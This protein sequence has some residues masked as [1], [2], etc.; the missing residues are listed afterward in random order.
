MK[1]TFAYAAFVRRFLFAFSF[2]FFCGATLLVPFARAVSGA[3]SS[4]LSVE[5]VAD[6]GPRPAISLRTL[7]RGAVRVGDRIFFFASDEVSRSELW[8][9]DGTQT[10]TR[11]V[12]DVSALGVDSSIV[13]GSGLVA[14]QGR[15]YF[16]TLD[17][18]AGLRIW[19]SDGSR[20]GTVPFFSLDL[21]DDLE[22]AQPPEVVTAALGRDL[23]FLRTGEEGLWD[24]WRTDGSPSGTRR[25]VS[26]PAPSASSS[27]GS[28]FFEA[29]GRAYF[30]LQ[31]QFSTVTDLWTTAGTAAGTV[32]L[33]SVP[34]LPS[35][36]RQPVAVGGRLFFIGFEADHGFELWTSDGSPAGTRIVRDLTPGRRRTFFEQFFPGRRA[37]Y[38]TLSTPS[39][40]ELWRSDGSEAGTSRLSTVDGTFA[41]PAAEV[42]GSLLFFQAGTL[43]RARGT[44]SPQRLAPRLDPCGPSVL[45]AGRFE[46]FADDGARGCRL[47][48]SDGT[49]GG[50]V[51]AVA[52][53]TDASEGTL[54]ALEDRLVLFSPN[55]SEIQV[56]AGDRVIPLRRPRAELRSGA[57]TFLVPWQGGIAFAANGTSRRAIYRSNGTATGTL[58]IASG[59]LWSPLFLGL[60]S[61]LIPLGENL[62]YLSLDGVGSSGSS[63]S[64]TNP[65]Q[66]D[67]YPVGAAHD[68]RVLF[69]FAGRAYWLTL[70][71]DGRDVELRSTDGTEAGTATVSRLFD[72]PVSPFGGVTYVPDFFVVRAE[73]YLAFFFPVNPN[74]VWTTDGTAAGTRKAVRLD[75][76]HDGFLHAGVAFGDGMLFSTWATQSQPRIWLTDDSA[77]GAHPIDNLAIHSL[78]QRLTA[79]GRL[80]FFTARDG[81]GVELWATDGTPSGAH[82]VR[83]IASGRR[84]S[85]PRDLTAVGDRLFFTADDGASGRELWSSDG[86][87]AGTVRVADLVPG[88]GGS[89]PQKLA[90][91]LTEGPA[92][93]LAFAANDGVH[94]LEPWL[95]EADGTSV[96]MLADVAPGFT[97]SSPAEFLSVGAHLYFAATTR[98]TGR[99]LWKATLQDPENTTP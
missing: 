13:S 36:P 2:L 14:A 97:S 47:W 96:R 20:E 31:D 73:R 93:V 90:A 32:R 57:P 92:P 62:A 41:T 83:D 88:P 66:L 19:R 30:A 4:S 5:P 12:L 48:R 46:F 18:L 84:G 91:V 78:D 69:S 75:G 98:A 24:L 68:G 45:A 16:Q 85:Y 79:V 86:T 40:R 49:A 15:A 11:R 17:P 34:S 33:A 3:A 42:E 25:L 37:L 6:L 94:G 54:V 43:W 38:F 35:A 59:D 27:G 77:Q 39:G 50:T 71:A 74:E 52:S 60:P 67:G 70:S 26:L 7:P 1:V 9:T 44:G 53:P 63:L 29:K 61:D 10:G 99:E 55:L 22:Q 80:A 23:L 21:F 65:K 28:Q 56:I 76:L 95:L 82:R 89:F 51:P 72:A 8:T 81:G 64:D 87:A 58:P